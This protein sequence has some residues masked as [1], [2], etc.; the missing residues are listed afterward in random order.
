VSERVGVNAGA[1]GLGAGTAV[2][3][4]GDDPTVDLLATRAFPKIAEALKARKGRVLRRWEQEVARLLPQADELTLVQLRDHLPQILDQAV[5]ALAACHH[6]PLN[7]LVEMTRSHGS[8]RFHQQFN[9]QEL[10]VEYRLLRRILVEE[11]NRGLGGRMKVGQVIVLNMA[12][13]TAMQ[14]GVM[15][16]VQHQKEQLRAAGE[17][18]SRYLSY[19]SHDLRNNLN[20]CTL[21]LE[22]LR[23][24][25]A[26]MDGFA[27]DVTDIN[28]IQRSIAETIA[29]MDRI[30]QAE[31]LRKQAVHPHVARVDLHALAT[32]VARQAARGAEHKG[33]SVRVDVPAGAAL[34]SDKE[35]IGLVLQNLVGNAVK[36]SARGTVTVAARPRDTDGD[37]EEAGR[38]RDWEISVTDQGPGISP[39]HR[40]RLFE[41]FS[42]GETHGQPGVGLGLAIA[43][44]A[45]RLLGGRLTVES[46]VGTGS[47]FRVVVPEMRRDEEAP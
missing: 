20:G 45:A 22:V 34:D 35:L 5:E 9:V 2:G 39:Q 8:M 7:E 12:V 46:E 38:T 33:L 21:M 28:T 42:R 18:Q 6:S 32:D 29:G 23:Q 37:G 24:R 19:L 40:D 47:T 13:D 16:F 26:G 25:L 11:I 31:R 3:A 14:Q 27:E 4:A 44:H 17:V 43:A 30:L 10:I 15:A 36:Y 1:G 41:A